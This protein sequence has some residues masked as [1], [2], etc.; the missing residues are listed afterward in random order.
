MARKS[1]PVAVNVKEEDRW[2]VE[3]DMRV[4]IDAEA[5][6]ADPKRLAKVQAMAREKVVEVAKI[7]GTADK[8]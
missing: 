1:S 7:A 3:N 4:L 6:K 5:I 2:R 8:A